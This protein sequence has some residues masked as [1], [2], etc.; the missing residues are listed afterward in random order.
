MNTRQEIEDAFDGQGRGDLPP[1]A[2]FTQTGTVGQMEACGAFWP[3]ANFD[4][5]KMGE[6]AIQMD[7]MFGFATARVP[8]CLTVEAERL[9]AVINPGRVDTQPS[10]TGSPYRGDVMEMD[11]PPE[12]L[13]DPE[14]F[15]TGGRCALV[16][17][18]ASRLSA[19]HPDLFVTAGMMDPLSVFMQLFGVENA[20]MCY[21]MEPGKTR[22]WVERMV[23]YTQAYGSRLSEA[24]DNVTVIG[25]ASADVLMPGMFGELI[26]PFMSRTV[27]SLR[28][29]FSTIHTCGDTRSN[30]H[31]LASI[32]ATGLSLE[33]SHDPGE[34][35]GAV[36]GRC[37][38]FGSVDPVGTLL[39]GCPADVASEARK[40]AELGF[41][42]ITPE[43]GVPP[44]TPD[45]NL[46]ALAHYRE[47]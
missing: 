17:E 39:M 44:R 20:L 33:A 1:P 46:D 15:A 14:E 6:L 5:A 18:V 13:M 47:L 3:E 19:E 21:M 30:I 2:V 7:R 28:D 16:Q 23:P 4:A 40:Y 43:C 25:L 45:A 29:S 10:I 31:E 22:E 35:L 38:L 9:G 37:R 24:A 34:Y 41:D 27:S 11:P 26:T 36:G 32:G 12:G 8:F 42:V